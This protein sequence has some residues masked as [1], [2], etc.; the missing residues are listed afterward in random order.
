MGNQPGV[1]VLATKEQI[2]KF[3]ADFN[4]I[5]TKSVD[6]KAYNLL[7]GKALPTYVGRQI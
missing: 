7:M 5:C 4:T 6:Q 2:N 1:E 3:I